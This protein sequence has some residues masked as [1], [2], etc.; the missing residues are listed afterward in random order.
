MLT[1]DGQYWVRTQVSEDEPFADEPLAEPMDVGDHHAAEYIGGSTTNSQHRDQE[2][3]T[4]RMR[5]LTVR[6]LGKLP[7]AR[8]LVDGLLYRNT[9]AQ[10][11]GPPGTYKSFVAIDVSCA[12]AAG[13]PSWEGHRIAKQE[14]VIYVA[15]EGASGLRARIYAWCS[16]HAVDPARL[17]GWLY[18]LPVPVQLGLVVHVDQAVQ[19]A[20]DVG[21]GLLVLDTRARCT[22]GLEE[23]SATE[24]GRAV[25]AADRIRAAA[26]C[27]V[28]G[29]HH[30]GRNGSA[31]RGSTAW[32]GAVW[33]DLRLTAEESV[34]SIKVEKHKDAPSGKTYEY[35]MVSQT[36]PE[37]LMPDVSELERK[38]LVVFSPTLDKSAEIITPRREIV[39]KLAENSCGI[40][41]LTRSK[42]VDLAVAAGLSQASAYRDVNALINASFLH[43][44]GT[45]KRPRY[46]YVGPTLDGGNDAKP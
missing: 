5:L 9:L 24:Q 8:P 38:S 45:D 42:L 31:P 46:A 6:D 39:A 35:R 28:W 2:P 15:A 30:S 20:R 14:K 18:V 44:V 34:V 12:L 41:G 11:S 10:L 7:T 3:L 29:I 16:R 21:A 25:D 37:T 22:L 4:L 40:E 13:E 19:M 26:G 1:E 33:S 32:D 43:N 27:T 17:D 36:V 23:N